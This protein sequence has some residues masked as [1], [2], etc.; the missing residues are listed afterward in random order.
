MDLHH[1]PALRRL[2]VRWGVHPEARKQTSAR[3]GIE[4]L[5]LPGVLHVPMLQHSGAPAKP[6]VSVGQHVLKGELI[7]ARQGN[8]SAPVHASTSGTVI[9]IGE[10]PAPHPSGLPV[11]TVSIEADGEDR[12]IEREGA[13]NPLDLPPEEIARRVAEAGVVGMG[14]AAFPSSVKIA[15]GQRSRVHTL[16]VNGSECEPYLSC[17]DRLMRERA[18]AIVEGIRIVLHATG[19]ERA[20]CGIE[21][22][23]PEAAAA[24]RQAAAPFAA[25]RVEVL[26]TRYPMGSDRQLIRVL[27]GQE[28][29]SDGR[30]A[31]IGVLVHNVG[32]LYAIQQA[33]RH[34]RPLLSRV[35]TLAGGALGAPRN[36]EALIGAPARHLIE[37]S[38]GLRETPARLLMGGPMMGMQ[39]PTLDAPIIKGCSGILALSAHELPREQASPCIRCGQCVGACPM[40]LM[41]FEMAAHIRIG[42][43]DA[44]QGLKD[45]I[46]CGS[47]SYVC[48]AHIP[49]SHYFDYAKG[50]LAARERGK[51]RQESIRKLTSARTERMEREARE[52]SEAAAR[53][54][55]ERERAKSTATESAS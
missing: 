27:T 2:L 19:A 4:T 41:P 8:I 13:E 53:R 6:V 10:Y 42:E 15:L 55:A 7:G 16:V 18:E 54:K 35:V 12:W 52:K 28:V 47:C 32:T 9:A 26:P 43:L 1:L 5:P 51:L 33:V 50:E 25:I 34:G 14:G 49:L 11:Q 22:N 21:D 20:L 40:N 29:P 38:G 46:G 45:C 31:D 23:K 24:M 48:P 37:H 3:A 30:S 39:L 36:I 44:A 17:D